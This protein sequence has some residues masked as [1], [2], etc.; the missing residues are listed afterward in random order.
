VRR[1]ATATLLVRALD[2]ATREPL[3]DFRITVRG[4]ATVH[5]DGGTTY[6]AIGRAAPS[7]V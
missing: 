4:A 2:G 1:V 5:A 3:R 7:T 6:A